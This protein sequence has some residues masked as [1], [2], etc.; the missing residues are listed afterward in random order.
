MADKSST[1][2]P[3]GGAMTR[4][5]AVFIGVGAMVG[6][7]IFALLGEAGTIALSAVW[8]SFLIAG[9]IAALQG[10][11]FAK[12]GTKHASA[13]GMMGYIAAGF[14]KESRMTSVFSWLVWASSMIVVA[15]VAVSF[16]TY[17]ATVIMG[18]GTPSAAL[19][20]VMATV[21]IIGVVLLSA[22]GGSGA[23]AK[24][25]SVVIRLVIIV[26]L[27]LAVVTMWTADWSMLAPST[28]PS[29]SAIIGS[30]A[31]TF[32]AFLGFG[33]ISYTA[34]DLKNQNDMGPATYIALA[35]ATSTYVAISLGVFGQL[36]PAQ[37]TA[38]GPTAI[39]LAAQTALTKMAGGFSGQAAY[40]VV[41]ITAML[42]TAGAVNATVYPV[43][44]LLGSLAEQ[45]VFPPFFGTKKGRFPI[46]LL[47]TGL[48]II[49][50]VWAF[51]LSAIASLGSAVALLI[52]LMISIGHFKIR[53][54][55]GASAAL[56]VLGILTVVITLL[57]FFATTIQTSP[58]S[59]VAFVALAVIAV[60][61]DSIWRSVRGKREPAV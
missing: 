19:T 34:K 30:I 55:T 12:L 49:V 46:S 47:L 4:T 41:T 26:L 35:I 20:Q 5:Q 28:Y 32:F 56:L 33:V 57:G 6:A 45:G 29:V 59:L 27:S 60:V 61:V 25:Q 53:K 13:S 54:D 31:L 44:G 14:G 36:T 48:L 3:S 23:V 11:S 21:I 51:D 15:M 38:A 7:G 2:A 52:F 17:A 40:A 9:I 39:A 58:A 43:P 10:Y 16:G 8:I 22:L 37:V 18:G 50:L 24:I 42:S 1:S